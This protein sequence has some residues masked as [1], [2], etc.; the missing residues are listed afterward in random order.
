MGTSLG[1]LWNEHI[2]LGLGRKTQSRQGKAERKEEHI[3][4]PDPRDRTGVR[5]GEYH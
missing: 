3:E 2:H 1:R 4:G 5:D